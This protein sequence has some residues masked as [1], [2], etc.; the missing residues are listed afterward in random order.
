VEHCTLPSDELN[1]LKAWMS[2]NETQT[3]R[4][5]AVAI[6]KVSAPGTQEDMLNDDAI[7]YDS[8]GLIAFVDPLKTTALKAIEKAQALAVQI[9][10][11][12]G[13]SRDVCF[14]IARQLGL[15]NNYDNVVLGSDFVKKNEQ[16]KKKLVQNSTVFARV[17]PEQKYEIITILQQTYSVGYIGDGINDAPALKIAQVGIAVKDAAAVAREAAEIILLEKSLLNIMLGV[18]E[19]RRIIINTLKY[20]KVTIASNVGHFYSL[21]FSSLLLNYLPML[22]LQL[23][24]LD[25]ITDFPLIGISSDRVTHQ[26]LKRPLLYSLKDIGFV[27]LLFGLVITPFD[28]LVF[29]FFKSEPAALQTS[30]FMT[31]ALEQLVLIFSL[32]TTLPFWRAHRPSLLLVS[33]CSIAAV[34]II[35]LPF[36]AFGQNIFLF[37]RPTVY[38]MSIVASITTAYFVATEMV[39]IVYYRCL[40]GKTSYSKSKI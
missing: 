3:N 39:K 30:W 7:H 29:M 23:L 22:P 4:V 36:T 20:I 16:E 21:I 8:L 19:G 31:S 33:L 32:R 24:F 13:D 11:L 10:I 27:V 9:K 26:E 25:L 35:V 34:V 14:T 6:K 12:S 1:K 18:E 28:F 37:K 38:M 2:D 15:E 5:I 17:N 40:F